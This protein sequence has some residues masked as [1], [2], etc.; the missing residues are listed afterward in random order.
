[1]F[2]VTPELQEFIDDMKRMGRMLRNPRAVGEMLAIG[3]CFVI[4]YFGMIVLADIM[5]SIQ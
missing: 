2:I 5:Q 4:M 3:T 1:M